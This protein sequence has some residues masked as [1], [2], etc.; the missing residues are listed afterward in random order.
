MDRGWKNNTKHSKK[1]APCA[2]THPHVYALEFVSLVCLFVCFFLCFFLCF[3]PFRLASV[4]LF[5]CAR[6]P[7]QGEFAM[8][9]RFLFLR[10]KKKT[11][12]SR[13]LCLLVGWLVCFVFALLRNW[14]HRLVQVQ[15]T[16]FFVHSSSSDPFF[17]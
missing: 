15:C 16:V 5:F 4:S 1:Y 11:S 2:S 13:F 6:V 12:V 7:R 14:N 8:T 17:G 9:H 10:N 3:F